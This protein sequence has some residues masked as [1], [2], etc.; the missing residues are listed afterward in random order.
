MATN[1]SGFNQRLAAP[2]AAKDHTPLWSARP[3]KNVGTSGQRLLVDHL[4]GI[5]HGLANA[6]EE[7]SLHQLWLTMV[8]GVNVDT[9]E[10]VVP[11]S[12]PVPS[13][14]FGKNF[15]ERNVSRS[16]SLV[17]WLFA[18][19]RNGERLVALHFQGLQR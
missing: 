7:L 10:A 15:V 9:C 5:E 18:V 14:V 1:T 12:D 16:P 13:G 4:L 19:W 6:I 3:V 8:L 11:T 17:Q 2:V